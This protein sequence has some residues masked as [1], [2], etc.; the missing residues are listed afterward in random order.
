MK[1]RI[2]SLLLAL[3]MLVSLLPTGAMAEE[4]QSDT[5]PAENGAAIS[6]STPPSILRVNGVDILDDEDH[7]VLCGAGT[8]VYD[9]TNN[10][11]TLDNATIDTGE[12][13]SIHAGIYAVG[14]LNIELQGTSIVA[15]S[16]QIHQGIY[17]ENGNLTVTGKG[18]L[19]ATG[20]GSGIHTWMGD[21]TVTSGTI[22]ATGSSGICVEEGDITVNGGDLTCTGTGTNNYGIDLAYGSMTVKNGTVTATGTS[23]GIS[24]TGNST[25]ICDMTVDNGKVTA[26]GIYMNYEDL[27]IENEGSVTA[28]SGGITL[29]G[30][31]ADLTVTSDGSISAND[32]IFVGNDLTVDQGTV[33]AHVESTSSSSYGIFVS[34]D[35]TVTNSSTVT[36][37]APQGNGIEVLYGDMRVNNSLVTGNGYTGIYLSYGVMTVNDGTV[38]GTGSTNYGINGRLTMTGGTVNGNGPNGAIGGT[39]WIDNGST[40][41][42]ELINLP[43]G[44]LPAGYE[45]Q[46]VIDSYGN[47]W[48]SIV[49]KG[50]E[51]GVNNSGHLTGAA[52]EITLKA[53]QGTD[54]PEPVDPDDSEEPGES[55]DSEKPDESGDSEK[56]DDS[57]DSQQPSVGPVT[58]SKTPSQQAVDKVENAQDGDT[59]NVNLT[60]GNTELDKE[61]FEKLSG[62]DVTLEIELPGGVTWTV[63]GQDIPEN[64]GLTDLDMSVSMD[65]N[66]IP[67]DLINDI[68]REEGTVQLTLENDMD[69]GFAM[70]LTAP[71]G[72]EN[73]SLWANLY[74]YD[75]D[76]GKMIFETAA[77]VDGDG[78][79]ASQLTHAGQY[80]LVLDSKS[81]VLPFTDLAAGAWYEDAV[82]YV[83]RHDLMVGNG[84]DLFSPNDDLSRAQICQII[85]NMEG[86]P[87]LTDDNLGYPYEDVDSEAW[88]AN[89]VYW[90]MINGVA[91]GYGDG[92]F[93]PDDTVT[94]EEFAQMMFNYSKFKNFDISATA[95]L[96]TF[97]DGKIVSDWAEEAMEWANGN[98]LINGHD[99]GRLDP[100]GTAIRAQAASILIKFNQNLVQK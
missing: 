27:I 58:P 60:T 77:Q 66:T 28:E 17:I 63:N 38:N 47:T 3:V 5:P 97:P 44:F 65:T 23:Y 41:V 89:A 48:A 20:D 15:N 69:F 9:S 40:T 80:A 37:I 74:Y 52:K 68:T 8:A 7:T 84:N 64:A 42:P 50:G 59:V 11:L 22:R 21:L 12:S 13:S 73:A 33:E 53:G 72:K 24:I 31:N 90:A 61:V 56:P 87:S 91:T 36:G 54:P 16:D 94:R 10:T 55:G 39:W 18:T 95:D 82:A 85:Y 88:Y 100:G 45:L 98:E 34:G 62:K 35:M 75:E 14:S 43:D 86:Q 83:Y 57:G 4:N 96:T 99:D 29:N 6:E 78:N 2:T 76:A 25:R 67:V 30:E 32:T 81:H 46:T 92:T 1:K 49:P 79:V 71:V 93:Q 51:L 19:E 70:T 26:N